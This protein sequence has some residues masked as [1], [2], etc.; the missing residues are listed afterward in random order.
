[1][2]WSILSNISL[3]A[4]FSIDV[5]STRCDLKP[6]PRIFWFWSIILSR[7][8]IH[9]W[10]TRVISI[11]A[12]ISTFW[13]LTFGHAMDHSCRYSC[14]CLS[15]HKSLELFQRKLSNSPTTRVQRLVSSPFSM[16]TPVEARW[17]AECRQNWLVVVNDDR[18]QWTQ[19]RTKTREGPS[20]MRMNISHISASVSPSLLCCTV[21]CVYWSLYRHVWRPHHESLRFIMASCR[22]WIQL[23][24]LLLRN[25]TPLF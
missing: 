4:F 22:G 7:Q 12:I 9:V 23:C 19:R 2:Y 15:R 3:T 24:S 21:V 25:L 6:L 16:Y 1:M 17:F 5:P 18:Q 20:S 11:D 10:E 13:S 8:T 14:V